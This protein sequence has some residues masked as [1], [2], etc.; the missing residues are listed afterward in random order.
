MV[1]IVNNEQYM[2]HWY[3]GDFVAPGGPN[4]FFYWSVFAAS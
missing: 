4:L 2:A 1:V 3:A